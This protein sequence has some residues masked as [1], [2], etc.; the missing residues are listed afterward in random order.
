LNGMAVPA[1]LA[2]RPITVET[3]GRLRTIN[4]VRDAAEALL[5]WPPEKRGDRW[6]TA[7]AACHAAL[8][9]TLEPETARKAF[10]QAAIVAEIYVM[11]G[12]GPVNRRSL[13]GGPPA[14]A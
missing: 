1:D 2:F 7:C 9:G 11:E 14:G 13:Q 3:A 10:V 12:D 8:A 5:R 4:T 6:R